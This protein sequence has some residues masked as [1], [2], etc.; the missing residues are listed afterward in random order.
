MKTQ[1]EIKRFWLFSIFRTLFL[2]CLKKI[3]FP[4][5]IDYNVQRYIN[6]RIW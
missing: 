2:E 6:I 3:I 4:K 1:A 5:K